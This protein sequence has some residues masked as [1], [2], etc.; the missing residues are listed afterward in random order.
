MGKIIFGRTRNYNLNQL[1]PMYLLI[2][3]PDM[4]EELPPYILN[5][6]ICGSILL[7]PYSIM[8]E[9]IDDEVPQQMIAEHYMQ[10]LHTIEPL[11]FIVGLLAALLKG[12]TIFIDLGYEPEDTF[13]LIPQVLREFF[14]LR[15][16][17]IVQIDN[18]QHYMYPMD[19]M[20]LDQIYSDLFLFDY[21]DLAFLQKY[22]SRHP[23]NADVVE[24]IVRLG[25]QD[26]VNVRTNDNNKVDPFRFLG[27]NAQ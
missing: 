14:M 23:F 13:I 21:A 3:D 15:Y 22:H 8:A 27:G 4:S 5:D 16:G 11:H 9:L 19:P 7:P 6:T 26:Q 10:Y 20:Y 12:F 18:V 17:I 24:K 2:G 25:L 1:G